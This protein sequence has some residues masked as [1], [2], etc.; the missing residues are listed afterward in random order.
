M[1]DSAQKQLV[2]QLVANDQ[3]VPDDLLELL[4]GA[5]SAHSSLVMKREYE[6]AYANK[7]RSEQILALTPASP[8]QE[9][10]A[11]GEVKEGEWSNKLIFGDNA[12]ALKELIN[13][14]F[15][16][17]VRLIYIDPPFATKQEFKGTKQQKAYA[18]KVIG[19]EFVE[20]IR[21]R[22]VLLKELLAP[23]GAIYIHLDEKKS[24]YIKIVMDEVFGENNF[25]R[26]II[27]DT[28]VL[29]GYKTTAANWIRG[30]DSILY[31]SK[32][33][34]PLFNKLSV[35]HREEYLRRFDKVD[36]GGRAYFERSA[37]VRRYLDDAI[38]KGKAIGDVWDDIM[39]FQQTPTSKERVDYP[40]QKPEALLDRI[41]R[42]SSNEG[43][44]ILDCFAG[45]GTTIAVAE[46]LGRRWIGIDCGKLAVYTIQSRLL[47]L[48][49]EIGNTGKPVK[50]KPFHLYSAGLYDLSAMRTLD[51]PEYRDFVLQLFQVVDKPHRVAG[52]EFDGYRGG[53]SVILWNHHSRDDLILDRVFVEA[54]HKSLKGEGGQNVWIIAPTTLFGFPEDEIVIG[55][56]TYRSLRVPESIIREILDADGALLRQPRNKDSVNNLVDAIAFDFMQTPDVRRKIFYGEKRTP[57]LGEN[58]DLVIDIEL[59]ES[60]G[61]GAPAS[62][63]G[64]LDTL[65][66]VLVDV[67]YDGSIFSHDLTF[68]AE[69]LANA[70]GEESGRVRVDATL[71]TDQIMIVYIDI[72]GNE[73]SEVV[74][75]KK[76]AK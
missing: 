49:K 17:K 6:L 21:H 28:A 23:D 69:D 64:N 43:D 10:R 48:K 68:F 37:G 22:L 11:F 13:Q 74:S 63:T 3:P 76:I 24:H 16:G 34:K 38:A 12:H 39:S 66:A 27:W 25:Q 58:T 41:I 53:D 36:E 62:K 31:Y 2:F 57:Q 72:F 59:F 7:T 65:A 20:F 35:P 33:G 45:S 52:I 44:I 55:S 75:T 56:T 26:E 15:A 29:S 71:V 30:H 4:K 9:A 70:K 50:T 73:F 61:I 19:S 47:N 5:S 54:F 1:L 18:D 67:N 40:T 51:F 46:K 32:N 60:T 8:F 14:G 42:A